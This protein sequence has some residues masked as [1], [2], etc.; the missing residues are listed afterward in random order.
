MQ[1]TQQQPTLTTN[2]F[3]RLD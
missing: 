3:L 1:N 2:I